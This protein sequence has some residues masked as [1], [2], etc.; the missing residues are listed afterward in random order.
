MQ[1]EKCP[2]CNGRMNHIKSARIYLCENCSEEREEVSVHNVKELY[3]N[4]RNK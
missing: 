4:G 2:T 3:I 1:H